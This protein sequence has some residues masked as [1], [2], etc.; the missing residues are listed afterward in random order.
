MKTMAIKTKEVETQDKI[1][2]DKVEIEVTKEVMTTK[3]EIE[4][5]PKNSDDSNNKKLNNNLG[6]RTGNL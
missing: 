1:K 2:T 3:E 6:M 4:D 5:T